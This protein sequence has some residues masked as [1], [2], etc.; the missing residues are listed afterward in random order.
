MRKVFFLLPIFFIAFLNAQTLP[1]N[2]PNLPASERATDLMGRLTLTE[3]ASLMVDVSPAIP[4]LG[5]NEYNWWN[6]ALHGVGR[7]GLATV[8]PQSI[9]LA[10][11]FDNDAVL[12]TFNIV[13]DEARAKH[14]YFKGKEE[15]KRYQGLTF[16][17]PNINIF[18]DPRW[19]RGQETYGEDPFLTT[20][21]GVAVVNGLQGPADQKYDKL[22]ACAKHYAVHSGPEWNRH[23]FDANN[24]TSRDLWE[25]YL[26]AFKA[27]VQ[28][29]DVK[30]VMCAYNRYEGEPC[31]SNNQLLQYILRDKWGFD[32]VVVSDCYAIN[33]LYTPGRHNTHPDKESSSADAV[34]SGTDLECGSNYLS[35]VTAVEQGLLTESDLDIPLHRILKA[36]FELGLMDDDEHVSWS[37][38][39]FSV[40]DSDKHKAKALEMARKSMTLLKNENDI[41]PLLK[42]DQKIAVIGPN[43]KD[44][45]AL[46]G[47]YSGT[48]SQTTTI[49][50]GI[51]NKLSP[52][53]V[54]Y[55]RGSNL[56]SSDVFVSLFDQFSW[57]GNKGFKATYWNKPDFEGE[58]VAEDQISTPF[59]FDTSGAT[60]FAPGVN[61]QHFSAKYKGSF[62]AKEDSEVTISVRGDDGYRVYINEEKVIDTWGEELHNPQDRE[63]VFNTLSGNDY[64]IEI[65]YMQ[66]GGEGTL[67]LDIG[68][69]K[70]IN[71]DNIVNK[72]QDAEVIVFVGGISPQV[73]GE[74]MNVSEAGFKGGD[75]TSIELPQVQRDLI[76]ALKQ[77]GKPVVLVLL[78]GSSLGIYPEAN[79]VDAILQAWYPGQAGGEAVAD[80]LFGD[81]NP[82]GRLPLTYYKNDSQLPDFED[83]SMKGRTYRYFEGEALYPFGY[84]LS[85]TSFEMDNAK[86]DKAEI[87]VGDSVTFN[88]QIKNT[89]AYDGDEVVQVYIRNLRDKDGPLKSL[90]AFKRTHLRKGEQKTIS[91]DLPASSFEFFDPSSKEMHIL[92]GK[93][94]VL[95]GASSKDE[96]LKK[97]ELVIKR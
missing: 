56:V 66:A 70:E 19:G 7:A 94:E 48:P 41:L 81:Y 28:E 80:V 25:T 84:G 10:A 39:P 58:V 42:K 35:L 31:C 97:L 22:H 90:R 62:A 1:Y 18:R 89:G 69:N 78:S 87:S 93:Y 32:G 4:R 38:I 92:P 44:S 15:F 61:L 45:V 52:N 73:E 40:V 5:I 60:V 63:Y 96:D 46:W 37:K 54:I 74:E 83:Y 3:K 82:A 13:S 43:A 36:R 23:V 59:N 57:N 88:L 71:H 21:M 24:I 8:F 27:L 34:L 30:E 64:L 68:H 55:D 65:D 33:D 72:V 49:L 9:G 76:H 16:W 47:N 12:N 6:E 79:E 85:Y 2:D 29:A 67:L 51:A 53:Q 91:M 95:Y 11:T 86:L 17:T 14:H 26:P 75:R 20:R 77:T 50:E